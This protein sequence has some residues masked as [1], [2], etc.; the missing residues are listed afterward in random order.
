VPAAQ[1]GIT[2]SGQQAIAQQAAGATPGV[3][4]ASA[5]A[6]AGLALPGAP[7]PLPDVPGLN[8]PP[9]PSTPPAAPPPPAPAP[10]PNSAPVAIAFPPDS[11]VL[12]ADDAAAIAAIATQRN[13]A[14]VLAGGFGDDT[15]LI[16][17]LARARRVADAL[18]AAGVPASA[19][20][21]SAMAAGSGGFVQLVYETP[22][23]HP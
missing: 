9:T 18:T 10:S 6:L 17:A 3:S 12:P 20:R 8:L 21:L 15:S 19:I 22:T 11:A 13:G 7:P 1:T 16:L 4:P 23:L 14:T 2:A 5:Q